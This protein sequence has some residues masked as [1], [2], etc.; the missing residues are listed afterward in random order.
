[1]MVNVIGCGLC[2]TILLLNYFVVE[3]LLKYAIGNNYSPSVRCNLL[4][5]F[6][7]TLSVSQLSH[8][9]PPT[10]PTSDDITADPLHLWIGETREIP[11]PLAKRLPWV[12]VIAFPGT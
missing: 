12:R 6:T 5:Y 3:W 7:V 10:V 2:D 1:M 8:F 4:A 9:L 11:E